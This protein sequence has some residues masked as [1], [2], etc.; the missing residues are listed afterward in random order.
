MNIY[1]IPT[2]ELF[3]IS[4][5]GYDKAIYKFYMMY[6]SDVDMLGTCTFCV[7]LE[8][9]GSTTDAICHRLQTTNDA[10]NIQKIHGS[11]FAYYMIECAMQHI[12]RSTCYSCKVLQ[13]LHVS[14]V[15]CYV[16]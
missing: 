11:D 5:S 6:A 7:D 4:I 16:T 10:C 13:I 3:R 8:R 15:T 2:Y 14:Y 1:N 9:V 12:L